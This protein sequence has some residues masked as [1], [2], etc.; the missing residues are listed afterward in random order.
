MRVYVLTFDSYRSALRAL[1]KLRKR[2]VMFVKV[3]IV[4]AVE[5]HNS[6]KD[7]ITLQKQGY[8]LSLQTF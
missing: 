6:V 3:I 2:N 7:F 5:H 1:R 4:V 8:E